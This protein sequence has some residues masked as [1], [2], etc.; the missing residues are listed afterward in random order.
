LLGCTPRSWSRSGA[1][2]G[3]NNDGESS[4]F[5]AIDSACALTYILP[6]NHFCAATAHLD[7]MPSD[8]SPP[9]LY[10][11]AMYDSTVMPSSASIRPD[12]PS[13]TARNLF[14]SH[15]TPVSSAPSHPRTHW[16]DIRRQVE[17]HLQQLPVLEIQL[18]P[19]VL[20][21]LEVVPRQP[22]FD[23]LRE[24]AEALG[25]Q[26]APASAPTILSGGQIRKSHSHHGH[27]ASRS[28]AWRRLASD[29]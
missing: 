9:L 22:A 16:T 26:R 20:Q 2:A 28:A 14:Y 27:T 21:H 29:P 25:R 17:Y 23:Q 8:K 10:S 12:T 4:I 24:R 1:D 3:C 6:T 19:S 11:F 15:E 7:T 18:L 13:R 5:M